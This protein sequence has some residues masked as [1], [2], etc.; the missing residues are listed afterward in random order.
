MI[1]EGRRASPGGGAWRRWRLRSFMLFFFRFLGYVF[2][3][4]S[5]RS[6]YMSSSF[7]LVFCLL[8]H[9]GEEGFP[10]GGA[11]R[12]W[13]F[14]FCLF[15]VY[16]FSCGFFM[17][18][19]LE[20]CSK[21]NWDGAAALNPGYWSKAQH[22]TLKPICSKI[23]LHKPLKNPSKKWARCCASVNIRPKQVRN[24]RP[25]FGSRSY[26]KTFRTSNRPFSYLDISLSFPSFRSCYMS[27]LLF[28][29]SFFFSRC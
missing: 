19:Y 10:G 18:Y 16:F 3:F 7:L 26:Q 6:C 20:R 27:S 28:F 11:C 24:I 17:G 8:N 21:P 13:F 15:F 22:P 14:G 12:R 4:F 9:G 25:K 23:S 29:F 5:F 1:M 2:S